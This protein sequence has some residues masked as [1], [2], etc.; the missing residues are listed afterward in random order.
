MRG[1]W[2]HTLPQRRTYR[3]ASSCTDPDTS[4]LIGARPRRRAS[5]GEATEDRCQAVLTR[6]P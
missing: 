6:V 4:R 1:G 2:A 3:F 5:G